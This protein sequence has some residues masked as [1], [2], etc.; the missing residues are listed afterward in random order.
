MTFDGCQAKIDDIQLEI[1]E[2]FISRAMG[3]PATGQ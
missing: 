3:L 1:D 2:Q